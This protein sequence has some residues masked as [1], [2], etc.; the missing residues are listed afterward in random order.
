MVGRTLPASLLF[1][2]AFSAG[3]GGAPGTTLLTREQLEDPEACR[4]CHPDQYDEWSG[5]MHAYAAEDP[6]FRAM[7][8]RA[9]RDNP[10]TGTFCVNCHAPL[11]V[12]DGLTSDG[13][14][15]DDIPA[16]KRGI[17]CYFC[18]AVEAVDG[19]HNNPLV[20]ASDDSLFGPFDRIASG[21]PHKG[22]YSRLMDD[23]TL[24]SVD[25]CG[26]CHDIQNLQ[27]AHV[28]RTFKEWRETVF[29]VSPGGAT[30]AQCHMPGRDGPASTL[31]SRV[32]RLH[33]HAFPAV[34]LA[35]T[36]F[37]ANN[38]QNDRQR[39]AAQTLLDTVIQA[40]LCHNPLTGRLELTLDNVSAG[41]GFPSGA[42][43]D[44]RAW[45]EL[46]AFAGG[47]QIYSSGSAAAF[48]LEASPDPDLWL[49]RDCLFDAAGHEVKM[50]WLP[51][52]VTSNVLP[53]GVVQTLTDPT[54]FTRTHIRKSY[55]AT[56]TLPA[57]PD[58]ATVRVH[59]KALGDDVLDDFVASGDLDP[60]VPATI[61]RY[62]LGGGAALEWTP[63]KATP[64]V[65]PMTSVTLSCVT[66][67][68]YRNGFTPAVSH[69]N[70]S[71]PEP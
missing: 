70:C 62:E 10:A 37:P 12:R 46:T 39:A 13:M 35:L 2:V 48:P 16:T 69:A 53:G 15:L 24:E 67:G 32:R 9:Q 41:H 20:L 17:T 68:T 57:T 50:F 3:C 54:S 66:S 36:P 56:G 52:T 5:S 22:I 14:N 19:T 51:T 63:S 4:S 45:V 31:S 71:Y 26:S 33:S 59:L 8:A 65:D 25:M 60:G 58:R 42:T 21:T 38:P 23:T 40:T 11:A 61:A 7:N 44:R 18:H 1:A 28:E 43:P 49:I 55:P 30:C 27:Q 47:A 64:R 6:V 29:A 34:D